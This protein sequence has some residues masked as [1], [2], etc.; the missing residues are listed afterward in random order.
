[1][2]TLANEG[3]EVLVTLANQR[4]GLVGGK[5]KLARFIVSSWRVD[6]KSNKET[7]VT[8]FS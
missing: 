4:V 2:G 1:M 5:K 3:G 6:L 8:A 7:V